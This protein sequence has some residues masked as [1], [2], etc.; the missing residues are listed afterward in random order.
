MVRRRRRDGDAVPEPPVADVPRPVLGLPDPRRDAVPDGNG[1]HQPWNPPQ[2][3]Q[4]AA[5]AAASASDVVDV[6]LD[7][8]AAVAGEAGRRSASSTRGPGG[9][10]TGPP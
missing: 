4:Y 7:V 3:R 9:R 10:G 5:A 1:P 2:K 6:E 8:A